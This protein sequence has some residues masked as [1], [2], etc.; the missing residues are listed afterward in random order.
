MRFLL[1]LFVMAMPGLIYT[2]SSREKLYA[3]NPHW[4]Q[5][6]LHAMYNGLYQAA[7][8]NELVSISDPKKNLLAK[9]F[10]DYGDNTKQHIKYLKQ[11]NKKQINGLKQKTANKN[12][13]RDLVVF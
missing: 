11:M 9:I 5:L 13:F 6:H 7:R 10:I 3:K 1:F 8:K 4:R 12:I 2:M